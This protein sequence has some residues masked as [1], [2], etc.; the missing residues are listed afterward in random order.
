MWIISGQPALDSTQLTFYTPPF[1]IFFV[2][3]RIDPI[4]MEC[5]KV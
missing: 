3:I 4:L 1:S 5:S 2:P